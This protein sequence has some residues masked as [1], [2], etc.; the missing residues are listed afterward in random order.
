MRGRH[1]IL[2]GPHKGSLRLHTS[3]MS[4]RGKSFQWQ[5]IELCTLESR[6]PAEVK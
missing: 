2:L 4:E 5:Q 3:E 1:C 6:V